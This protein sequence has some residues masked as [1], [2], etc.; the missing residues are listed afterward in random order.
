MLSWNPKHQCP[1]VEHEFH[2]LLSLRK[3]DFQI[4]HIKMDCDN[5]MSKVKSTKNPWKAS[6]I[7]SLLSVGDEKVRC[8]PK[9]STTEPEKVDP[10]NTKG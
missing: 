10:E 1:P 3:M 8:S 6:I 5:R 7:A 4:I 9:L 2:R